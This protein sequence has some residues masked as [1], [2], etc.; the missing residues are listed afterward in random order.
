MCVCIGPCHWQRSALGGGPGR[1]EG[2]DDYARGVALVGFERDLRVRGIRV[3]GVHVTRGSEGI[4]R[5]CAYVSCLYIG[6]CVCPL[7]CV[8]YSVLFI[9]FCM[10]SQT[11]TTA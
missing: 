6:L 11:P 5:V 8:L 1:P 3:E 7:D 10:L 2:R 9:I 4:N